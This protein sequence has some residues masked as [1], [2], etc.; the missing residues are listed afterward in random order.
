MKNVTTFTI[1]DRLHVNAWS[2]RTRYG[3]RHVAELISADGVELARAIR[4]YYNRTWESYEYESVLLEL[5]DRAPVYCYGYASRYGITLGESVTLW[6][7][8]KNKGERENE[9]LDRS[10]LR[11]IGMI[12]ALGSIMA[13]NQQA[14]NDW[15][16]RMLTAGLEN[17]GLTMPEDWDALTEDEKQ[18]RLDGAI[19]Q[20]S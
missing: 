4:P 1:S 7:Y 12:A 17:R 6:R 15:K 8:I 10:G 2:E 14:A 13:P 9:Y 19:S 5:H 16:K 20:L 3:F 11:T 18:R